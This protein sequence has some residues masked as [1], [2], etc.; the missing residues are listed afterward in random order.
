[1]CNNID[2]TMKERTVDEKSQERDKGNG[3]RIQVYDR[4]VAGTD[5]VDDN[6]AAA[7]ADDNDDSVVMMG[8]RE[9][10][11]LLTRPFLKAI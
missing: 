2:Y 11:Y 9:G 8:K 6:N 3:N 1:M 10:I 7:A 4:K 5:G